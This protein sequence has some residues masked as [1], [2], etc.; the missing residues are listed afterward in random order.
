VTTPPAATAGEQSLAASAAWGS[1]LP[2]TVRGAGIAARCSVHLLTGAGID[3]HLE[4]GG[5]PPVPAVLLSDTALALMRDCLGQPA[6]L[7]EAARIRRRVVAWGGREPVALDHDAVVV[8]EG[9]LDRVI[10][11]Q[12]T[13]TRPKPP[14][15][16]QDGLHFAL[17]ATS[18]FPAPAMRTFGERRAKA[19]PVRLLH[20][21]DADA[22]WIE[23]VEDGWLF[24]IPS[25]DDSGWLL[26][27]GAACETLLCQSRH[28]A[29]RIDAASS[30]SSGFQTAPRL[31]E[32][33]SG[34]GWLA[35]GT[36]AIAFD[37]ICGDG[38]AQSVREA[39]LAAAV[40]RDIADGH[41]PAPLLAH[42][43][44]M[45]I[46]AMRRHLRLCAQFYA[47]GG[48]GPW[49]RTQLAALNQGFEWCTAQLAR[50]PE[51]AYELRGFRLIPR[52]KAA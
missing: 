20:H 1:G 3:V 2:V 38:T 35:C 12:A 47:T 28:L 16:V 9:D 46:A 44:A 43:H 50:L 40:I 29:A 19:S 24:M 26:S 22:C 33:L 39:I 23:A 4:A 18:P 11:P 45:L 27:V 13:V 48:V 31:L 42:Y 7:A 8:R 5:R 25:G 37:P 30:A 34:P 21:E 10:A 32:Q 51:P 15:P 52:S 14:A 36:E 6:L 41:D 17:H 49:W